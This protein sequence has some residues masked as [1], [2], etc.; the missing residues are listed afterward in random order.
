M[1]VVMFPTPRRGREV[2]RDIQLHQEPEP[3]LTELNSSTDTEPTTPSWSRRRFLVTSAS[4]VGIGAVAAIFRPITA[5][6]IEGDEDADPLATIAVSPP[7]V[8]SF[9]RPPDPYA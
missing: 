2:P 8:P 7:R 5:W 6:A 4:V 9:T 1:E 3:L